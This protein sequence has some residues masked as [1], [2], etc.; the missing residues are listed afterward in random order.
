M[1]VQWP[2]SPGALSPSC[3]LESPQEI[4]KI[5]FKPIKGQ[6][7]REGLASVDFLSSLLCPHSSAESRL[8]TGRC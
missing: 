4:F 3:A 7:L 5:H 8:S 2:F 1:E 6:Y